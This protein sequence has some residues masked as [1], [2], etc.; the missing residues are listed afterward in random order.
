MSALSS[1]FLGY[2]KATPLPNR[3]AALGTLCL[4]ALTL[5]APA[6]Q[7]PSPKELRIAAASDLRA[8]LPILA[9]DYEKATG[10]HLVI[11]YAS[12]SS[13]ATQII[14][15]APIDLFLAA[16]FSFPEKVVA[17]GRADAATPTLY[18]R[19]TLVLWARKDSP[20]QP[21]NL[22]SLTNPR[23]QHIAIADD[24]RAPYGIAAVYTLQAMHLY[25]QLKPR[26][27]RADNVEQSGQ[28]AES[29]NAQL[30]FISLSQAMSPHMKEVG[31]Y[32]LAPF[33]YPPINQSAIVVKDSANAA[34]AH[35]FLNWLLSNPI[36]QQLKSFGFNLAK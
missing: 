12:S 16:D 15:G 1:L 35:A 19:G 2:R 11:S 8:S 28:F 29:G 10:T 6:Q 13:L 7:K 22:D 36:Q 14:N 32:V 4:A 17:A 31:T 9:V 5:T 21:L 26:L 3:I 23:T 33:V 30:A 18:A 24:T 27:V 20:I 34:A 25:D